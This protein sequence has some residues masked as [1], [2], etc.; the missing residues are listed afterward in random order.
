M[1]RGQPCEVLGNQTQQRRRCAQTSWASMTEHAQESAEEHSNPNIVCKALEGPKR[2][3]E[4]EKRD[5]R[6]RSLE[7]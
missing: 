2:M 3:L 7:S 6:Y 5:R 4:R 1:R